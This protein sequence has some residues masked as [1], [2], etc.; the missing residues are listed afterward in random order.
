MSKWINGMKMSLV[1]L[2]VACTPIASTAKSDALNSPKAEILSAQPQG[3]KLPIAALVKING[4][5]IRLEV[6]QTPEQQAI[7]LMYRTSLS[8]DRGMLFPFEPPRPVSFWMK[9]V[10]MNLDMIFLSQGRVSAIAA[11]VPPC[12]TEPCPLYG[13]TTTID[14]VIELR[15]GQAKVLG[16]KVG[17]RVTVQWLQTPSTQR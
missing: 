7:G 2:L 12:K 13:P 11:N 8:P 3:Q 15:G 9:N 16:L 4:R 17:D 1:A 6:A 14:Q 10:R 5:T